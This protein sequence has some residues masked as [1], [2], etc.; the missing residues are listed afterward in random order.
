[1]VSHTHT[2]SHGKEMAEELEPA[3]GEFGAAPG[4][5]IEDGES[6]PTARAIIPAQEHDLAEVDGPDSLAV[7]APLGAAGAASRQSRLPSQ[8]D[9]FSESAADPESAEGAPQFTR[10]GSAVGVLNADFGSIGSVEAGEGGSDEAAVDESAEGSAPFGRKKS[11]YHGFASDPADPADVAVAAAAQEAPTAPPPM[12]RFAGRQKTTAK[13][14][15]EPEPESAPDP[16]SPGKR[17]FRF[18]F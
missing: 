14:E 17:R 7:D 1:M 2:D 3:D 16:S 18:T 8:Y 15:P 9:G 10:K 6:S 11:V 4:P 5:S 12:N 13:K